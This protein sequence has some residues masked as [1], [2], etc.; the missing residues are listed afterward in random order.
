MTNLCACPPGSAVELS[1]LTD[2]QFAA[3]PFADTVLSVRSPVMIFM[4][5]ITVDKLCPAATV[6]N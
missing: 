6:S 3:S 5:S 4:S 1:E 2:T